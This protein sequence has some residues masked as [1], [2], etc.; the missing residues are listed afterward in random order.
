MG[1]RSLIT[2]ALVALVISILPA[3]AGA[4]SVSE[5]AAALDEHGIHIDR[6]PDTGLVRTIMRH[7]GA[8][9]GPSDASPEQAARDFLARNAATM[10]LGTDAVAD[11]ELTKVYGTAHNGASHVIFH[12]VDGDRRVAGTSL[13]VSLDSDGRVIMA[14]G[15]YHAAINAQGQAKLTAHEAIAA[16]SRE[17][18]VAVGQL[19]GTTVDGVTRFDNPVADKRMAA[20]FTAE[21]V[22]FVGPDG[23]VVAWQTVTE[24]DGLRWYES[25]VDA[26]TGELLSQINYY[27]HA[28]PE[29]SVFTD[30]HPDASGPQTTVPFSGIDGS[31]MADDTT[32]G[33]NVDAYQ[34]IDDDD[35]PSTPSAPR[36]TT[37]GAADPDYQHFDITFTDAWRTGAGTDPLNDIAADRDFAVV[38][39][40]YYTNVMHDYLYNLGFDE[41]A[42]NFQEDNFGRGGSEN[43]PVNAEAHDGFGD[44]V[45]KLCTNS[46]GDPIRCINNANFGT[47][48]DG[49]RPRMQMYL[50]ESPWRDGTIDGD[51]I[52]H[53]YGHGLSKRLV[54]GGTLGSG[55][56]TGALGEG[57][58]DTTSFLKWG[59]AVIG[60]YVTGNP[61][62]GI[63]GVAYDN[64]TLMYSNFNPA[65]GVHSNGR[66][67]AST[68]YDLLTAMQDRYGA[69]GYNMTELLFVDGL[70]N[71]VSSPNYL[72]FRTGVLVADI[73]NNGGA[74]ACLIWGVFAGRE[75]GFSAASSADQKT[76]TPATDG[77][78]GCTPTADAGGP[79]FTIEGT[80]VALDGTGSTDH[81][82]GT[83]ITYAW[84]FDN[85]GAFDDAT[86]PTPT[87]DLVGQDGAYTVRLQ[88]TADNGG[89]TDEDTT[90]VTVASVSPS[91]SLASTSPVDENTVVNVSGTISD[92]GWLENLTGTIDWDDG[93]SEAI[94]GT[95][96]NTRPDATLTFDMAHT[97]GDNGVFNVEVCGFD[98]DSSTCATIAVTVN[99]VDP[100][101]DIDESGAVT[102]NGTPT[103]VAH[104]G[105]PVELAVRSIDPGSDDLT[106]SWDWDDGAPA[107]D[108]VTVHLVNPPGADPL[109]SPSIQPRDVTDE[110][111]HAF[112]DAC[113]YD[114]GAAVVDDD[115]G[116]AA[117]SI[118][119]IIAGNAKKV[120]S[121]GY[122]Y[123][124]YRQ[125]AAQKIDD[126]TLQCY[127]E[128][129]EFM[130]NVFNEERDVSTFD[131]AEALLK[132]GGKFL[133]KKL[134]R[135]LLRVYLNF[136]NGALEFDELIDTDKDGVG[137][138]ELYTVL[139]DAESV[140][141]NPAST[142]AELRAQKNLLQTINQ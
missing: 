5:P 43:D 60:E 77:P 78:P 23:P 132:N 64:S 28:G 141:L 90:T 46:D 2:A 7:R 38:Q 81:P 120:R 10:G 106:V 75:M 48:S 15:E 31:W 61:T 102:V 30:Q 138:T 97:Y 36:P 110:Q 121:A 8:L 113:L 53:E 44:G 142:K 70:K 25:V 88:V 128:I 29:G 83:G 92:P 73:L 98:D 101:A 125:G 57:W 126:A 135:Q 118:S 52:A 34:D 6:D 74:N 79:Y 40:F 104:A 22:T 107:P 137:D 115:G 105:D 112:G 32:I 127:L 18:G 76:E 17:A 103:I 54:G 71:T 122:W 13:M 49:N 119:V 95:L 134:D 33:N 24:L 9:T 50:F 114:V 35:D 91:V 66:I 111:T 139:M 72:N 63:R 109:P 41:V 27:A 86:G 1:K 93:T 3:A 65:N 84:D 133:K 4:G 67:M 42:G 21:L 130:S 108:V 69:A 99:N 56:Q 82:T 39:M 19:S 140:R 123:Q 80:D 37:P 116:S 129:I 14:G 16:V 47:P 45:V 96:E 68:M 85:D 136:A 87:F 20:D 89:F 94:V 117:D 62:T 11:L 55:P 12:Q 51:V 124:Q 59:D 131:Q 26:T 58:S 100:T